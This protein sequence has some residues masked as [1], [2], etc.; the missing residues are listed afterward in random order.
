MSELETDGYLGK[1]ARQKSPDQEF[2]PTMR[3]AEAAAVKETRKLMATQSQLKKYADELR[4]YGC[5]V[6]HVNDAWIKDLGDG[7]IQAHFAN[8]VY[9]DDPPTIGTLVAIFEKDDAAKIYEVIDFIGVTIQFCRCEFVEEIRLGEEVA[10]EEIIEGLSASLGT[11]EETR[12]PLEEFKAR[13]EA[14]AARE[15]I[16]EEYR[17]KE[18]VELGIVVELDEDDLATGEEQ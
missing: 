9:M 7:Q 5:S 15:A 12:T 4:E 1:V 18:D 13:D 11:E 10:N 16:E 2:A 8:P 3:R 6:A 14:W 17:D